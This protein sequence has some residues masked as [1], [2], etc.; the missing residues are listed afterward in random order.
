MNTMSTYTK[1][2]RLLGLVLGEEHGDGELITD[3]ID[4]YAE[5]GYPT[6]AIVVTGNW[7]PKRYPREGDAPLTLTENLGPRLYDALTRLGAECEWLDEWSQCQECYKAVR[8]TENSYHWKPSYV[9]LEDSFICASC[10]IAMG[11]DALTDYINE[12]TKCVT[13]C[14]PA[15]V[16]SLGFEQWEPDD[17]HTYES[18]WH[19]GQTDDPTKIFAEIQRVHP[20]AQVVFFLS[21]ASQFYIRFAAYVR[22]PVTEED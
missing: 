7:N 2:T 3:V 8:T 22:H 19:P 4:G 13:W 14:E 11:E 20:D 16:E 1:V 10:A 17:P 5:P 15:H 12:P 9:W 18:G 6:D 21:E